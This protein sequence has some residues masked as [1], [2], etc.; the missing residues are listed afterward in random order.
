MLTVNMVLGDAVSKLEAF[1]CILNHDSVQ[2]YR[3]DLSC[4][5][6]ILL[7]IALFASLSWQGLRTRSEGLWG[8]MIFEL[9]RIFLIGCLKQ[10]NLECK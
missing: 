6:V 3:H 8:H 2:L 1:V 7:T 10:R 9:I 4:V 5:G